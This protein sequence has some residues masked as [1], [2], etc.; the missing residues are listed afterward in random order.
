MDKCGEMT[1]KSESGMH[2]VEYKRLAK[3]RMATHQEMQEIRDK[4][5]SNELWDKWNKKNKKFQ[6]H[7]EKDNSRE[8]FQRPRSVDDL[9]GQKKLAAN[10]D[11]KV[12]ETEGIEFDKEQDA[13]KTNEENKGVKRPLEKCGEIKKEEMD[14]CGEMSSGKKLKKFLGKMKKPSPG[15]IQ[16]PQE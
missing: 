12:K 16:K 1:Y 7:Q 4:K 6:E 11:S 9:A 5:Q 2:T 8:D 14:K 10:E 13:D 15:M 3:N